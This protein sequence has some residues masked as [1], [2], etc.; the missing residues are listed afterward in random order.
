MLFRSHSAFFGR[1]QKVAQ[2]ENVELY[3]LIMAVSERDKSMPTE[4]FIRRMAEM[5]DRKL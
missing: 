4:D 5:G 1:F 3:P 2:E